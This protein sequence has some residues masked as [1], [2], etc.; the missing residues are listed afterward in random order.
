M[1]IIYQVIK[2]NFLFKEKKMVNN[3][4]NIFLIIY[5][6]LNLKILKMYLNMNI[7]LK[8]FLKIN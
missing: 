3:N 1:Q 6:K 4:I 8:I 2:Y 7:I 5:Q